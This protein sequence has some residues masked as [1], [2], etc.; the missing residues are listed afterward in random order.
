MQ[1]FLLIVYPIN[2]TKLSLLHDNKK[3]LITLGKTVLQK[4]SQ[5]ISVRY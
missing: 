5:V 2:V 3:S 4:G 1:Q